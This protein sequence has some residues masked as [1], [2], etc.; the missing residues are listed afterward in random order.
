MQL[1][2]YPVSPDGPDCSHLSDYSKYYFMYY[3]DF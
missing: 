1:G 3:A 2:G